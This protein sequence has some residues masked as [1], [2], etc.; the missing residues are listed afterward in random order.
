MRRVTV[1]SAERGGV[2]RCVIYGSEEGA[3][4]FMR[5]APDDGPCDA[6]QWFENLT[7]AE[8]F[9]H[10]HLGI[11]GDDWTTVPDP[12]P[13]CQD[14]WVAP[15]HVK[16]RVERHP[17]WGIFERLCDDGEWREINAWNAGAG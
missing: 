16:G 2:R 4:V 9:C 13:G 5:S 6:E 15:V 3:F 12:L 7:T 1:L 11:S 17:Q 8:A 14:D 10:E